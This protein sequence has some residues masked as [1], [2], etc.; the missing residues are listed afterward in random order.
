MTDYS[1]LETLA[2]AI[3]GKGTTIEMLNRWAAF[4]SACKPELIL[5]L[6]AENKRLESFKT[7]YMEWSDKTDWVQATAQP[8]ELGKHR[9]DVLRE[10]I[11][12]LKHENAG[13]M[14]GY[15][16]YEQVVR[17]LRGEV[18]AFRSVMAAVVS[19]VPRGGD[20]KGNAPGHCHDIPG[21]W[22]Q[23]NGDKSGKECGWCKVWNA[24]M[25]M[26]KGEQA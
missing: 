23:G 24:A 8:L 11:E 22:D 3:H 17:G 7:S 10:R 13:L 16:A 14:T 1:N 26:S 9:A 21:V 2:E 15:E 6:I 4:E 25:V 5:G 18:E 20:R 12:K 19:E